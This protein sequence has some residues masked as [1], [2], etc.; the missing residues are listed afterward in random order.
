[1]PRYLLHGSYTLEGV[2]G[3]LQE[4]GSARKAQFEENVRNLGG[5][6]EAFYF[7]FGADDIYAII[8]LPDSVSSA[9]LSLAIS[10]GGGFKP[11]IITLISPE[12]MDKAVKKE[13][14]VRYRPPGKEMSVV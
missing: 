6:V 1:M 4:G 5:Q 9:A 3:L 11:N 7:A 14:S 12:E 2:R 8:D 13:P 10:T